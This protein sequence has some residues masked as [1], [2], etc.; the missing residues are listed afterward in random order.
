[1]FANELAEIK[2]LM[3]KGAFDEARTRLK[4]LRMQH[5]T[6]LGDDAEQLQFDMLETKIMMMQGRHDAALRRLSQLLERMNTTRDEN[7][8][9][10]LL[11]DGLLLLAEALWRKGQL[12]QSQALI[13]QAHAKLQQ[14]PEKNKDVL[15]RKA[16]TMRLLGIL[17]WSCGEGN[18]S[19]KLYDQSFDLAEKADSVEDMA[20]AMNNIGVYY[21]HEGNTST[22]MRYYNSALQLFQKMEHEYMVNT[23]KINLA[24]AFKEEARLQ[25]ALHLIEEA[26]EFFER[27]KNLH[28]SAHLRNNRA[29]LLFLTG[30]ID[31]A[32]IESRN[33]LKILKKVGSDAD[34]AHC[35]NIIGL[36]EHQ[37]GELDQ[38][39]IDFESALRK[40]EHSPDVI[41]KSKILINLV[42]LSID[43]QNLE[44]ARKHLNELEKLK[45][46]TSL[47]SVH[48]RVDVARALVL[49]ISKRP[50]NKM[51]AMDIFETVMNKSP[52]DV[53]LNARILLSLCDLLLYELRLADQEVKPEIEKEIEEILT[54][55]EQLSTDFGSLWF[56]AEY[57]LQ[58]SRFLLMMM[59]IEEAKRYLSLALVI[60]DNLGMSNLAA[61][62]ARQ[63]DHLL[64]LRIP[65]PKLSTTTSKEHLLLD[66][67]KLEKSIASVI[68]DK[69][70]RNA[71]VPVEDEPAFLLILSSGGLPLYSKIFLK[72]QEIQ[73][74]EL[75]GGLISA[76]QA[77]GESIFATP[78]HVEKIVFRQYTIVIN[79]KDQ[80]LFCYGFK[81]NSYLATKRLTKFISLITS[82]SMLWTALTRHGNDPKPLDKQTSHIL[83]E[84]ALL[85]S[86]K[87][88]LS[89][90]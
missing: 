75:L 51:L 61:L 55:F 16:R 21:Y 29:E 44:V 20:L 54:K 49:A 24:N 73:K 31:S 14:F 7:Q 18:Q 4:L 89:E 22:A 60:A 71:A 53:L 50:K 46:V 84:Y 45:N 67:S 85:F 58:R 72:N 59:N 43:M 36:A 28:L 33:A 9:P 1:M 62:I 38:A 76:I 35:L 30:N 82:N 66:I 23:I 15:K 25:D 5:R 68:H 69:L 48:A 11:I 78:D 34:Q 63:H 70:S 90:K 2:M 19:L 56:Q 80:L 57:Y 12:D 87:E 32:L 8:N 13:D 10:L 83:E 3:K 65:D 37:K 74:T 77:I 42:S 79:S 88:F 64:R 86:T 17:R 47:H 40:I 81:K 52:S 41:L 27:S 39:L 6:E 26:L